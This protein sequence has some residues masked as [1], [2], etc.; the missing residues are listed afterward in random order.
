MPD[1]RLQRNVRSNRVPV[2]ECG[3]SAGR[4]TAPRPVAS[5]LQADAVHHHHAP[6]HLQPALRLGASSSYFTF[7]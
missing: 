7:S 1:N 2:A 3:A 4:S 5:R 6:R